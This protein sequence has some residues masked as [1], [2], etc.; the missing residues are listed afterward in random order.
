LYYVGT[1]RLKTAV[2][3][4]RLSEGSGKLTINGQELDAYF[5]K[6]GDRSAIL[7]PLELTQM[8][9]Q[10]DVTIRAVGGDLSGQA[11][12]AQNGVALALTTLCTD[13]VKQVPEDSDGRVDDMVKKLQ[14]SGYLTRDRRMKERKKYG[15]KGQRKAIQF[16]TRGGPPV[17]KLGKAGKIKLSKI[18]EAVLEVRDKTVS[19]ED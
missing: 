11:R 4:V 19:E 12:A 18:R 15:L 2:V 14:G 13:R 7:A 16:S 3:R 6:A 9:N 5:P 8:R 1:G 10:I 17:K